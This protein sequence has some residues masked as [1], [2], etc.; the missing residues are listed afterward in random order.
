LFPLLAIGAFC[1][2]RPENELANLL[3][4]DVHLDDEKPQVVIR[5]ETGKTRRRRFV[6][7]SPNCIAWIRASGVERVG[8]VFPAPPKT[9]QR[10]RIALCAANQEKE[11]ARSCRTMS[12]SGNAERKGISE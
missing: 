6:D 5:P 7:V 3:W 1:G 4:E 11:C 9:L 8:K 12:L 10:K 2:L